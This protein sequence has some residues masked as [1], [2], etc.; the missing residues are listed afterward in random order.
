MHK[1]IAQSIAAE[2][3]EIRAA[4]AASGGTALT[5]V[6]GVI[7]IPIGS[8]WVSI[9]ARNFSGAAVARVL[10]NPRLTIVV[11]T[12]ALATSGVHPNQLFPNEPTTITDF[13]TQVISDEMQDGDTEDF[14]LDAIDTAANNDFIYVGAPLPFRG[15]R[16]TAGSDPQ[17]TASVLTV[18]Y[19]TGS[20]GSSTG[21]ANWTDISDTD[22]TE[23]GGASFAQTGNVT[24]TVPTHWQK[25]SLSNL[26]DTIIKESWALQSLYWTRWEFSASTEATWNVAE[27]RALNRSTAYAELIDGQNIESAIDSNSV[28]CVEALTDDGTA[29]LVVNVAIL[30]STLTGKKGEFR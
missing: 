5:N 2:L 24:W 23:S 10:L 28:A 29:N 15:A 14:A 1:V 6:L 17:N 7:S 9:T 13:P 18:K 16:I 3:T 25:R 20:G 8:E 11:T 12:D 27:I 21:A 30:D 22:G 4:S 19:P 26:G